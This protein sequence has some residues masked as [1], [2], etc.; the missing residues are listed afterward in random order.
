[1]PHRCLVIN[2]MSGNKTYC[3]SRSLFVLCCNVYSQNHDITVVNSFYWSYKMSESLSTNY[4][5]F[6]VNNNIRKWQIIGANYIYMYIYISYVINKVAPIRC[7]NQV[8]V[9][10]TLINLN[11]WTNDSATIF[12]FTKLPRLEISALFSGLN[13]SCE[14]GGTISKM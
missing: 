12:S 1:M 11:I 8:I 14:K 2:H 6:L 7:M 10:S 3:A 13:S 9:N 4:Q 5:Y